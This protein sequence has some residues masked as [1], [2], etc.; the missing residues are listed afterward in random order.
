MMLSTNFGPTQARMS[1]SARRPIAAAMGTT[2]TSERRVPCT[3]MARNR[4]G[5]P[6]ASLST[7]TGKS[8][9]FNWLVSR[10][11]ISASRCGTVH[12]ATAALDMN[13]PITIASIE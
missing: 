13:A 2:L 4:S 8:T 10:C 6:P 5:L 11:S 9:P 12:K 1:G 3:K 7:T